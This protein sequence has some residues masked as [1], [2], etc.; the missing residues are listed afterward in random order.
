[1]MQPAFGLP[2]VCVAA[3]LCAAQNVVSKEPVVILAINLDHTCG[4]FAT[5]Y[6]Y[7]GA[8]R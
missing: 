1:M 6:K 3:S 8:L 2:V 7:S 5:Y 4:I